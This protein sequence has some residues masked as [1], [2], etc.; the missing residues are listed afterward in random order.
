MIFVASCLFGMEKF[1]ADDIDALGYKRLE[2]IDGRVVF[3]APMDAA[4]RCNVNFRY[5]ERLFIRLAEFDAYSF[6]SLFE[7]VKAID[8]Q[9]Y[10][11]KLDAFPVKGHAIKSKLFSVPDCQRIVKKAI[12]E[13]LKLSYKESFFKETGATVQ[14]EF[15]ILKDKASIMID[16][17]GVGLHKRGYRPVSNAAPLRETLAAA[18]V[19]MSRPREGVL[20]VDPL[21]GSGTI[22]IEAALLCTNTAPGLKRSFAGEDIPFLKGDM[23][24]QA[25]EEAVSKIQKWDGG[26]YGFDIDPE[27]VE[28]SRQNAKR[29]GVSSIVNFAVGDVRSFRSPIEG[30]RGTIV[31]NPPYG[32][33][34][35]EREEVEKLYKDMGKAF[36]ESVPNWQIYVIN[37]NEM[38]PRCF[39]RKADKARKLYNGMLP[40]TFYQFFKKTQKA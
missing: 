8:W 1:V 25:R 37:S 15:F 9:N 32:E 4:A 14:I 30:A 11:G 27:C 29:A 5:A 19:T 34:M 7:G 6:D 24:K 33:R 21:C 40:C 10:I 36:A 35:G 26:I 31:T 18:L 2:T 3:E 38:F 16:T 13:K 22:P 20:T 23:W 39:G 28:L 17:S 12:V